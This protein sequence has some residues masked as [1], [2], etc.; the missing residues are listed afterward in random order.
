MPLRR[1]ARD[2]PFLFAATR[3]GPFDLEN[4]RKREWGSKAAGIVAPVRLYNLRS[5]FTSLSLS[6]LQRLEAFGAH[7]GARHGG[8]DDLIGMD[9]TGA[10]GLEPAT[11]GVAV[12][13]WCGLGG[14][15]VV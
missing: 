4:F 14:S 9:R 2:S 11:S 13:S 7:V 15:R 1:D 3:G 5:T 8:P 12:L 6:L 10:T